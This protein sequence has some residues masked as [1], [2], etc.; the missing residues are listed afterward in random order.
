MLNYYED[1]QEDIKN[2]MKSEVNYFADEIQKMQE[3]EDVYEDVYDK[4]FNEDSVTGNASGSYTFNSYEAA[5]N[6]IGNEYLLLEALQEFDYNDMT[7]ED[8]LKKGAEWCDVT[9]RC[10]VLATAL[11]RALEDIYFRI[12][13]EELLEAE[14]VN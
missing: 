6:L 9:I 4:L 12:E 13:L 2:Y 11:N 7:A 1:V 5:K 3:G 10:Y 8:L 14:E